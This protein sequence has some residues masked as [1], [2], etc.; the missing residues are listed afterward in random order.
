MRSQSATSEVRLGQDGTSRSAVRVWRRLIFVRNW[1]Q[2]Y[3]PLISPVQN[4]SAGRPRCVFIP[5]ATTIAVC[6]Q[7][8]SAG[9]KDKVGVITS[10][11]LPKC[12]ISLKRETEISAAMVLS[13]GCPRLRQLRHIQFVHELTVYM[14]TSP[15]PCI[16][17]PT[18]DDNGM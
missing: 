14:M 7:A 16:L 11:R 9:A 18:S 8:A 13:A 2:A 12:K 15:S 6:L 5:A 1:A 4:H 10:W 17:S 3:Q